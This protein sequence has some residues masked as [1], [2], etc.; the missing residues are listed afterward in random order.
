VRK[1]E[2]DL[3]R[4]KVRIARQAPRLAGVVLVSPRDAR[5]M[6]HPGAHPRRDGDGRVAARTALRRRATSNGKNFE[7]R[8]ARLPCF[9]LRRARH[10]QDAA[11]D[12][13]RLAAHGGEIVKLALLVPGGVD[14]SGEERVIPALLALIER[15]ASAHDVHVF[16]THQERD[17]ATWTLRGAVI[18]NIGWRG[19]RSV[20]ALTTLRREHMRGRFDVVQ[21]IWAGKHALLA[22]GFGRLSGIPAFVSRRRW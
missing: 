18:H 1:L 5:G 15:L 3:R 2:I 19:A 7:R 12:L 16:A 11:R 14:R 13:A 20:R 8:V 4:A 21:S 6:A 9:E 22:V 10:P 17:P